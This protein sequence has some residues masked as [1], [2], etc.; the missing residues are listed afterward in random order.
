MKIDKLKKFFSK[1]DVKKIIPLLL[2]MVVSS[3]VELISVLA[4]GPLV[5]LLLSDKP[6]L[7]IGQTYQISRF[8]Y[9]VS[10]LIVLTTSLILSL[11]TV[12]SLSIYS[13]RFGMKLSDTF[14]A[15]Y[16]KNS[17]A[18]HEL[19]TAHILKQ[20]MTETQRFTGQIVI[21]F[22]QAASKLLTVL[23][24]LIL[25]LVLNFAATVVL[26]PLIIIIY[27]LLLK[28]IGPRITANGFLESTATEQ[29]IRVFNS[30]L[31]AR[32]YSFL[33]VDRDKITST[34]L[35]HSNKFSSAQSSNLFLTQVPRYAIETSIFVGSALFLYAMEPTVAEAS[36]ISIYIFSFLKL[37]PGLQ[38]IYYSY[39]TF[40]ANKASFVLL[41]DA[42]LEAEDYGTDTEQFR[43]KLEFKALKY[44]GLSETNS[45]GITLTVNKGDKIILKGPSGCGKSSLLKVILGLAKEHEG[46]IKFDGQI[47]TI[48]R[49]LNYAKERISYV[50][51]FPA[52]YDGSLIEVMGLSTT[53]DIEKLIS[54]MQKLE[55]HNRFEYYLQNLNTELAFEALNL[56]GGEV[57]KLAFCRALLTK[58]DILLLDEPFSALDAKS[59]N[60][61]NDLIR[62]STRTF[63]IV[64][65]TEVTGENEYR[66]YQF[67]I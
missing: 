20:V 61:V 41:N 48:D 50:E 13:A 51:Q 18:A 5:E 31:G 46:S 27:G 62:E 40:K 16:L 14:F 65:H 19:S 2:I 26:L 4:V 25:L 10:Y 37:L 30:F 44:A 8:G 47:S 12:R 34:L 53:K 11:F 33:Y 54:L 28:M 17:R 55:L 63:I 9:L 22:L 59:A 36:V 67:Q 42:V 52:F 56:S 21:P 58:S 39:I 35:P 66:L 6:Y 43:S 3:S 57:Q 24:L 64:S 15:A 45:D 60:T 23:L 49:R 7:K 1:N 38:Q 29:R 32:T